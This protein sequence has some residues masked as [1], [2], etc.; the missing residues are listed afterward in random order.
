MHSGV[1]HPDK[2]SVFLTSLFE[3]AAKILLPVI[4]IETTSKPMFQTIAVAVVGLV[5]Y[6]QCLYYPPLVDERWNVVVQGSK[7]FTFLAMLCGV[8][9][10]A[11]SREL[12]GLPKNQILSNL[13]LLVSF[14]GVVAL[15]CC[16]RRQANSRTMT[17]TPN[18]SKR[19]P[20]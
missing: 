12:L 14:V 11:Q 20:R 8:L 6:I 4:V 5:L 1:C 2:D 7:L 13:A 17:P 15:V 3:L 9:T 16:Q 19:T 10:V 18:G